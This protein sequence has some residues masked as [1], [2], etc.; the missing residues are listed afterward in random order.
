[1][2]SVTEAGGECKLKE[3]VGGYFSNQWP[4]ASGQLPVKSN[5]EGLRHRSTESWI[6]CARAEAVGEECRPAGVCV[7]ANAAAARLEHLPTLTAG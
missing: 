3:H 6:E 4:V 2:N 5:A 7:I 1:M